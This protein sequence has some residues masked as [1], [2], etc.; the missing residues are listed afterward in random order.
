MTT[1][2]EPITAEQVYAKAIE[3]H[4]EDGVIPEHLG[5]VYESLMSKKTRDDG[6]IYYTPQGVA[7]WM[8]RFSLSLGLDQVGPEPEQV[9]RVIAFDPS[10]GCGIFLVNAARVLAHAYASR[11][12]EGEPSGDLMLAV[13]PRVILECVF[14]QDLD[15]V[16][17]DLAKLALSMETAG[18]LT[19]AMLDRH[20]VY[21]DTLAGASPPAMEEK[22]ARAAEGSG[23]HGSGGGSDAE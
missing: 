17:V 2:T 21:G 16:A 6:A 19:P 13:L 9:M 23:A 11:L 7:E 20:V 5:P 1:T 3:R 12:V 14:G 15:P 22:R 4:G 8:S 18:A 10:C